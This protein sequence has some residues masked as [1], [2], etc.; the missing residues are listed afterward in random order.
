M[1]Y[2]YLIGV[3]IMAVLV[4]AASRPPRRPRAVA[5]AAFFLGMAINEFPVL[6]VAMLT[7]STVQTLLDGRVLRVD[8][9][10]VALLFAGIVGAS[11][12]LL[13]L[14]AV[15]A[16]RVISAALGTPVPA[17][18][19]PWLS[20]L[21]PI[22]FRPRGVERLSGLHYAPGGRERTLDLY[23]RR[24][25]TAPAPTLIYVHAGGYV[26]GNKRWG[27]RL[28]LHR[29]AARGWVVISANYGLRPRV[30]YPGHLIDA[31]R[32]IAWVHEEAGNFGMDPSTIVM[33]GSSA[34]AHL[35]TI[36]GLTAG[37]P[38]FQP[39]FE[40]VD[41]RLTAMIGFFGYYGS[42]Y[43]SSSGMGD[44]ATPPSSPFDFDPR[45]AP[46]TFLAHGDLDSFTPVE[47]ARSL[48]AR[49][50]AASPHPVV[51]AELPGAQHGFDLAASERFQAV[52]DGVGVFLDRVLSERDHAT[53]E[54]TDRRRADGT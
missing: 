22:T 1:P 2:G 18:T 19:P 49:L 53:P 45:R 6:F 11:M 34:G 21:L 35:A 36:A 13:Q 12:V 46:A 14:R 16:R 28:L 3:A 9:G 52:V 32:V 26:S 47:S 20:R 30:G 10:W 15:T 44:R 7:W 48:A 37:D 42:Y 43:G 38:R 33:A 54:H 50:D 23:R 24:D 4:L 27:A 41:T 40:H 31:K 51:Y 39:G 25:L 29:M 5:I 17:T 8:G